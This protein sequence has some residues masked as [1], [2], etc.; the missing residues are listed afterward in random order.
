[1]DAGLGALE[2]QFSVKKIG[3]LF[4]SGFCNSWIWSYSPDT[5]RVWVLLGTSR[6]FAQVCTDFIIKDLTVLEGFS[7][8]TGGFL[9]RGQGMGW[10]RREL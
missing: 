8:E 6:L 10:C 2:C 9:P 4:F 1:M 7:W 5:S 3:F